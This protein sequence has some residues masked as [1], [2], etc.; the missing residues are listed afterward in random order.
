M[1]KE[2]LL[3]FNSVKLSTELKWKTSH[4][5]V[6]R[7]SELWDIKFI[8]VLSIYLMLVSTTKC[9]CESYGLIEKHIA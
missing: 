5:L 4:L 2:L 8:Q 3:Y 6:P 9:T 7:M 1:L